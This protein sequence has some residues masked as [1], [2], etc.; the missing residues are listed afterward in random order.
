MC[1]GQNYGSLQT[2]CF[3][4]H[5][6]FGLEESVSSTYLRGIVTHM[7]TSA[8]LPTLPGQGMSVKQGVMKV[9]RRLQQTQR[10]TND[11]SLYFILV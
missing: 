1:Y 7:S 5:L 8:A 2:L 10:D 6:I 11:T 3:S 9:Q 4:V